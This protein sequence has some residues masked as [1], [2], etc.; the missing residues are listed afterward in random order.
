[1]DPRTH[2]FVG[3]NS[4]GLDAVLGTLPDAGAVAK[5]F[6]RTKTETLRMLSSSV[7]LSVTAPTGIQPCGTSVEVR[8]RAR[9]LAGHKLPTGYADGRRVFLQVLAEG[10]V[11]TGAYDEAT[12][13]LV[14]DSQ[15]RVYQARHGRFADGPGEHLALHDTIF[16]DTRIPPAGFAPTEAT[17]PVGV[18][19]FDLAD[20]G[21]A[22]YG[23]VAVQIPLFAGDCQRGTLGVEARLFY[24]STTR[25]YV[26]FLEAQN[27]TDGRGAALASIWNATGHAAPVLM[28]SANDVVA[29]SLPD[30]CGCGAAPWPLALLAVVALRRLRAGRKVSRR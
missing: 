4:W 24:Q 18:T 2:V 25:E 5:A 27:Q 9:N 30:G 1:M 20:G 29:L 3:G 19:W 15:L 21:T 7:E 17:R 16:E 22:D 13:T 8:V 11:V 6:A 10:A 23:E 14:P 12:H 26:E 28:A